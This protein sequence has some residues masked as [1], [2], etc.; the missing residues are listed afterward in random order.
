MVKRAVKGDSSV[1]WVPPELAKEG[2]TS[3]A[4]N[5]LLDIERDPASR[6]ISFS[7]CSVPVERIFGKFVSDGLITIQR[8]S[9]I[10]ASLSDPYV[11]TLAGKALL[12]RYRNAISALGKPTR[13]RS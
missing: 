8:S 6:I 7:T 4:L 1:Q 11:L 13:S 10:Y 12:V 2:I 9:E 3:L 5:V